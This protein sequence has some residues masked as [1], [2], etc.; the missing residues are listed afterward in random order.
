NPTDGTKCIA[1]GTSNAGAFYSTDGGQTWSAATG[2]PTSGRIGVAYSRSDPTVVYASAN[3]NS[4]EV[5]RSSDGGQTYTLVSTGKNYLSSQGWYD[6]IIWVDPTNSNTVIVGGVDLWRGTYDGTNVTLTQISRWQSAPN[7]AHADNHIVVESSQFDGSTNKTVFFGNDGGIYRTTDVYNVGSPS[8]TSG[9]T[10][11]NNGLGITQFYGGAGNPASGRIVGGTQD[12]GTLRYTGSTSPWN[13][14]FGGDGGWCAADPTDL[15]YFYGEYVDLQIH[16]S[17]NGGASSSYIWNGITDAGSGSTANF[18]APFILDPNNAARVYVTFG[19]FTTGNVWRTNDSGVNWTDITSNLP[20]AP[21][22][23]FAVWQQNPNN[24]Y[25]G[26][27]VGIF[28]SAN[29]GQTWSTSNDGPTN[30]SVDDLFWMNNTLVA[31]THGR[32]MF[33]IP[34]A[35]PSTVQLSQS[36]YSV[37]EANGNIA[38]TITRTDSTTTASVSYATSDTAGLQNCNVIN[39]VASSRCDYATTVGT[40][41]FAVGESS[42]TIFIPV[43]N[44]S[45]AE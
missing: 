44:D 45:Y 42:K 12:N 10:S 2:V 5:Y 28:A 16:R 38:V 27:E 33:S 35:Q 14:P 32:G 43:V 22:Y 1:S 41:Q 19:G 7:S 34:L 17:T 23:A 21:V 4:G 3:A 25:A 15:N 9:W 13:T 29:G 39:G 26:T 24:L 36:S 30:C 8:L 37:G 18:I 11:L 31:V 20:S 40:L 6:N